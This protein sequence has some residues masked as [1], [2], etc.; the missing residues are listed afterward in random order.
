MRPR[1]GGGSPR[2][3]L[4]LAIEEGWAAF[5]R[6]PWSFVAFA[7]LLTLLTLACSPLQDR[8]SSD[9]QLSTRALDWLLAVLGLALRLLISLWG[10]VGLVRGAG[11]A[12][13]GGHPT[14]AELMRW[15][16]EAARRV[17]RPWLALAAVVALPLL[18]LLLLLGVAM[19][20]LW[21]LERGLGDLGEVG[22]TLFGLL[23]GVLALGCLAAFVM[24]LLYLGVNQQFLAQIALTEG[25]GAWATLQRGRAV[26]D[27][28]WLPALLLVLL[29]GLLLLL[30]LLAMGVGLF[31]AWPVVTC[32]TTA[33]FRQLF[34]PLD[35]P[36]AQPN[37]PAL[38][39]T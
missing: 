12:L 22:L 34:Q 28:H 29:K 5:R 10:T 1:P 8:I 32:V 4:G 26:V 3:D 21:L 15:D 17:L 27:P 25:P 38:S 6:A 9:G 7:L 20:V 39:S 18:A 30:G 35:Q 24:L 36:L 23:L 19:A 13:D 33:A 14:L 31:V 37:G 16:G 11:Q 2:L